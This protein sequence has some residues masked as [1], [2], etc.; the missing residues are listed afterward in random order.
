MTACVSCSYGSVTRK[1]EEVV[2]GEQLYGVENVFH[3]GV[4][5]HQLLQV[6]RSR[7]PHHHDAILQTLSGHCCYRT[8]CSCSGSVSLS[9]VGWL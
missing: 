7:G 6:G 8:L 1:V 5:V 2:E 3:M 4:L 9:G